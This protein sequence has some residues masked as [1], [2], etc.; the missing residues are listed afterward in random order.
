V[1]DTIYSGIY[2]DITP[3]RESDIP[4]WASWFNNKLVT[5][6]LEQGRYPV[7]QDDQL[8][9][10]RSARSR[11]IFMIRSKLDELLGTVSL[12]NID[13]FHRRAQVA[14]VCPPSQTKP[15][16]AALESMAL[17]VQHGFIEFGL[18][19]IYAGQVIDGLQAW[20]LKLVV[21]GFRV[22]GVHKNSFF[23]GAEYEDS[24]SMAITRDNFLEV[25]QRLGGFWSSNK[26]FE[27]EFK[28]D[29]S[30]TDSLVGVDAQILQKLKL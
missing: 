12:S 20:I 22:E 16:F 17:V 8:E 30:S 29:F 19:R 6:N 24:I 11:A 9:F 13:M 3:Y 14:I 23:N 21:L 7:S 28:K 1:S 10:A 5:R 26:V 18:N 2:I 4:I 25:S 27:Q 15:H